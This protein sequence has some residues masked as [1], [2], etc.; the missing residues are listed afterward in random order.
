[1]TAW[2]TRALSEVA[3]TIDYGLT[4]AASAEPVGPKFLRITDIQDGSV[5]WATV[6]WCKANERTS[7]S[8]R[9]RGGDIVFARTGATTGKSFLVRECPEEAVFASYLIRIRLTSRVDPRF[10]SYFLDTPDYWGQIVQHTRGVAQPGVNAT[11]LKGLVIPLP[12]LP[13]QRRIADILDQAAAVR[14]NRRAAVAL[15]DSLTKS[16]FR[17]MFGD[18]RLNER[19]WPTPNFRE[20]LSMPLRNGV[21]PSY[22]GTV[23]AQVLT[24]T[25]ITG[26]TFD[27]SAQK[28]G[29]FQQSPPSTQRV[30]QRDLLICRG[31]GNLGLVGRGHF[32]P[33]SMADVVFPDTMIA[34]RIASDV[35]EP[36]FVEHLWNSEGLRMQLEGMARTTNG[37]LK[38]NQSMLESVKVVAP[39]LPLQRQFAERKEAI[40][41]VRAR[42]LQSAAELDALFVSLQHRG[43]R[44]EL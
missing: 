36:T 15:L 17:D 34:A 27:P 3:E 41:R 29:T 2:Q 10:L 38:V 20:W 11:R 8:F 22:G 16:I 26:A 44:G 7:S 43:F 31:N 18:I 33:E 23:R 12:P 42:Y 1:M 28:E 5:N 13:E 24:L 9:L 32:A 40:E 30:D 39:P 37:T 25:A 6:P 35:A 21:S 4:A 19:S 14:A